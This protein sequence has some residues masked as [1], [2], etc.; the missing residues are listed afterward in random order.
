M[1][2][3]S[4]R[5]RWLFV[6]DG[7]S[8][9][10]FSALTL[11][12]V[13]RLGQV[14]APPW[15]TG[16]SVICA[17][18]LADLGSGMVHWTADTWGSRHWP[19]IGPTLIERFRV[20]HVDPMAITRHGFLET[21]GASAFVVLP[22]LGAAWA[23]AGLDG[24]FATFGAVALGTTA[25]LTVLTNQFHK[26]A[27]LERVPRMVAVLQR[28]RIILSAD[29]HRLHHQTPFQRSYC[30]TFGWLNPLLDRL[31]WFR[32]LEHAITHLTGARPRDEDAT[33]TSGHAP[34]MQRAAASRFPTKDG[35]QLLTAGKG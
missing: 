11:A 2:R 12:W 16:C 26:W 31:G 22:L 34:T 27:H 28:A 35:C 33:L 9:L 14:S 15:V 1:L 5:A 8:L 13:L 30:I 24:T 29:A 3:E 25:A 19:V 18:F 10:A 23:L 21:N 7:A 6:F 4:P 32:L 20:H 17:M